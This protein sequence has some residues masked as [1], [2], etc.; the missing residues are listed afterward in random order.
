MDERNNYSEEQEW[1]KESVVN[2]INKLQKD[3]WI[4]ITNFSPLEISLR[5]KLEREVE[6]KMDFIQ[7]WSDLWKSKYSGI[8]PHGYYLASG[9]LD[10]SKRMKEFMKAYPEFT[11]EIIQQATIKYLKEKES[12]GYYMTKKSCKFIQSD[13]GSVLSAYCQDI[14]KNGN[15][16]DIE[17]KDTFESL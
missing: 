9:K 4:K 16:E 6:P 3:K 14:L 11:P 8:K 13:D 5:A 17:I 2:I 12:S 15:K 7:E 1:T 10:D